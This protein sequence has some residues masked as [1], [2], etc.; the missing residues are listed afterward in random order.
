[1]PKKTSKSLA[2]LDP[3]QRLLIQQKQ[4]ERDVQSRIIL[5]YSANKPDKEAN[6]QGPQT[7]K[8]G[9]FG[10]GSTDRMPGATGYTISTPNPVEFLMDLL[11]IKKFKPKRVDLKPTK[12]PNPMPGIT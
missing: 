12:R 6:Y 10:S 11:K 9:N 1:M 7:Y 5:P 2:D 8:G 4:A 3:I